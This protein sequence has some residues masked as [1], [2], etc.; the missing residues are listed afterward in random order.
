MSLLYVSKQQLN[1]L[2]FAHVCNW[3]LQYT[4]FRVLL[5]LIKPPISQTH[6]NKRKYW[7]Q[8]CLF[9]KKE[10]IPSA[11]CQLMICFNAVYFA[12][13]IY[14]FSSKKKHQSGE[15]IVISNGW[16][17]NWNVTARYGCQEFVLVFSTLTWKSAAL[18]E[19]KCRLCIIFS[20]SSKQ[21]KCEFL[22]SSAY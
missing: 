15:G 4:V 16:Q 7:T 5:V 13:P 19:C 14:Q 18:S 6:F 22:L 21:H 9:L 10:K 20:I 3:L 8:H 1:S 2:I 17:M 12:R 11:G